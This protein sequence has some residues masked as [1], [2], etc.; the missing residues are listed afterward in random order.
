MRIDWRSPTALAR[1]LDAHLSRYPLMQPED[2]Y[3]LLSQG[4]L[5]PEHLISSPGDESFT[6]RRLYVEVPPSS[7][8][9]AS[10]S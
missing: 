4:I 8:I 9:L 2:V 10:I 5:G 3:K 1:L 6:L 7:S